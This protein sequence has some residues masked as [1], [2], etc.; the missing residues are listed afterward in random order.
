VSGGRAPAAIGAGSTDQDRAD[1]MVRAPESDRRAAMAGGSS[2]PRSVRRARG[3]DAAA[4]RVDSAL[5]AAQRRADGFLD[6]VFLERERE[7]VRAAFRAARLRAA[8]DLVRAPRRPCRESAFFET[9]LR[10]SRRSAFLLARERQVASRPLP[11][12]ARSPP[13]L[14]RLQGDAVPARLGEADRDR[15]PRRSRPVL[16][17]AD[18]VDLL[19]HELARLRGWGLALAFR[20]ARPRHGLL[21]RHRESP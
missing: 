5:G 10:P 19:A 7:R 8:G 16:P 6:P 12:A 20:L 17:R 2:G 15:L 18:V 1:A 4:G 13:A 21:F 11:R 14:R 3:R 9:A